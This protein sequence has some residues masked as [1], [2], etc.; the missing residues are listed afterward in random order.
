MKILV[1][2]REKIKTALIFVRLSKFGQIKSTNLRNHIL[3][4]L[5][6]N[7]K[8]VFMDRNAL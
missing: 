8:I 5:Q 1:L 4:Y 6:E 3:K 7:N 2:D